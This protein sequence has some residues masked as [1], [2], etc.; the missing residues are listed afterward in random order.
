MGTYL[1]QEVDELKEKV[2]SN[3]EIL[4]SRK[5]LLGFHHEN[6][7]Q[8]NNDFIIIINYTE[9]ATE[10]TL[11]A[12]FSFELPM[13]FQE[14]TNNYMYLKHLDNDAGLTDKSLNKVDRA[15]L[16]ILYVIFVGCSLLKNDLQ[17]WKEDPLLRSVDFQ[18]DKNGRLAN[19]SFR[20]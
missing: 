10:R 13:L 2:A 20:Y 17:N 16:R 19:Y 9:P 1:Q 18:I 11:L 6:Q 14:D 4:F 12:E 5:R 15:L 8:R 7:W 3:A